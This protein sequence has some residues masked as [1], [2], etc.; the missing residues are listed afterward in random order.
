MPLRPD[1]SSNGSEP[2]LREL[3]HILFHPSDLW[4]PNSVRGY[5]FTVYQQRVRQESV[6]EREVRPLEQ[7]LKDFSNSSDFLDFLTDVLFAFH[8]WVDTQG[9]CAVLYHPYWELGIT[10]DV[11]SLERIFVSEPS[12]IKTE[13]GEL[14]DTMAWSYSERIAG[15]VWWA[16][17]SGRDIVFE[18]MI[19]L[20]KGSDVAFVL[21]C[22][23]GVVSAETT[24]DG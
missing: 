1:A 5:Q 16:I 24:K 8:R 20:N 23:V 6:L 13:R 22:N 7:Y 21:L 17:F 2:A 4:N 14:T 12:C 10:Y 9:V 3:H 19:V 11:L 15:G 18:G